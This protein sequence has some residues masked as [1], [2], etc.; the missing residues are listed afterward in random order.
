MRTILK[1]SVQYISDDEGRAVG[2]IVPIELWRQIESERET[3]YLLKSKT[4]KKRLLD[5][6]RR[7]RYHYD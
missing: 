2:V 7:R 3:S 6:K 4:M 1:E 5:A